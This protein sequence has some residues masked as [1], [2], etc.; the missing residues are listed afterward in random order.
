M[1]RWFSLYTNWF[2]GKKSQSVSL[3]VN[4]GFDFEGLEKRMIELASEEFPEKSLKLIKKSKKG[5]EVIYCKAAA[6]KNGNPN[7]VGYRVLGKKTS[8]GDFEDLCHV[9]FYYGRCEI[10]LLYAFMVKTCGFTI[11]A[12]NLVY[13][14][15]EQ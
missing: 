11:K 4:P 7:R 3:E 6:D 2:D 9:G 1:E 12:R 15:D 5:D 8:Y 10:C 14:N 13:E